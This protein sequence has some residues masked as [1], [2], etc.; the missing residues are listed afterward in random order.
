[1]A[2]NI[3]KPTVGASEDTW[4]T[5]INTAL[6]T[7]VDAVNGTSGTVAPDHSTLTINGTDVTATAAEIN[8]LDGL[9][10]STTELNRLDG[11]TATA[12]ELNRMDGIT[13]STAELNHTDGVTSNI[14]TQLNGKASTSRTISAGG[15]LTGGGNLTANRT[16]SHADTSSQGS[17]NN[18][19]N[20]FIQDITL[21]TYGH[22]TNINSGS[23]SVGN[24]TLTVQGTGALGGSG[25]FTAN[26]SGNKTISISH[27]DTSSQS[28][29]NNSG[30]T[31][32][33]DVT[34]DGYGH[35]TGLTSKAL[36][37]PAAY[38]DSQARAAQHVSAFSVGQYGLLRRYDSNGE[39]AG[40]N[41]TVSGSN[42]GEADVNGNGRKSGGAYLVVGGSW[43]QMGYTH[44]DGSLT[45]G[46]R[47]QSTTLF[48]RYA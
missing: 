2:I 28:S 18:S 4:G 29:V 36:S 15:G 11:M 12:S 39:G 38:S 8:K 47:E 3:T 35:V 41:T 9:T 25:T 48:V 42:L 26:Q 37:I 20:T 33:Q 14:Q 6:D 27:D 17:V 24:G 1:M 43:R 16:I 19:G 30:N 34:L 44:Y 23:V 40:R 31:V 46:P 32:I 7:I 13:A 10:A 45:T 21:D 5:T 22:I